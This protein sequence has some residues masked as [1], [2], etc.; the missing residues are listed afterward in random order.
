[1]SKR[2]TDYQGWGLGLIILIGLLYMFFSYKTDSEIMQEIM[3]EQQQGV[4]NAR[5]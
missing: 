5:K 2:D 1:M 3:Q 4:N